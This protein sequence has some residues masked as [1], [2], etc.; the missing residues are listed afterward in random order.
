MS[1]TAIVNY[2]RRARSSIGAEQKLDEIANAIE[3]LAKVLDDME[4]RIKHAES[5]AAQAAA[6]R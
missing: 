1:T 3:A 5:Y 4:R 2:A 6:N